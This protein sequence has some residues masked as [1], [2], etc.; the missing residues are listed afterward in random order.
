MLFDSFIDP[1]FVEESF[2]GDSMHPL[3]FAI[4]SIFSA[5]LSA[6]KTSEWC[7]AS[8]WDTQSSFFPVNDLVLPLAC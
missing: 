8:S 1:L 3:N 4:H 7:A 2:F 5:M 6:F